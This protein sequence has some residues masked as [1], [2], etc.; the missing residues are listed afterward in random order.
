MILRI[1][2]SL[3]CWKNLVLTTLLLCTFAPNLVAQNLIS[4]PF[5][6]D[7]AGNTTTQTVS[8]TVNLVC[9]GTIFGTGSLVE[10]DG[11]DSNWKVVAL[12]QGF[13]PA[14]PTPYNAFVISSNLTG[15]FVHSNGYTDANGNTFYWVAP[16]PDASELLS[17][18]ILYNCIIKQSIT[19][20]ST[21]FYDLNFSVAGDDEITMFANGT[22]DGTNPLQPTIV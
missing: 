18:P 17:A 21:G 10:D 13:S 2:N 3:K 22:I 4:A 12:P 14:Q 11:T 7:A 1:K 16:K 8:A 6:T 20:P 19:V 15:T 5:N 9:G